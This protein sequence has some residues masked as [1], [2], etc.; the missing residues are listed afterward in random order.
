MWSVRLDPI[1]GCSR[2]DAGECLD[3][4]LS[5][6]PSALHAAVALWVREALA[7]DHF[8]RWSSELPPQ[9]ERGPIPTQEQ[10]NAWADRNTLGLIKQFPIEAA[11]FDLALASA[12]ATKVSWEH[13]F[14]VAPANERF[15]PS[16]PWANTD[17]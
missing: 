13:P 14:E 5:N 17:G 16:S 2:E 12:L 10:A 11:A 3:A 9:I 6:V 7:S 15:S 1:V 4:F 8:V